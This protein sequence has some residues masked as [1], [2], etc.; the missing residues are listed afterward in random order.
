MH[1]HT[2][3]N[4]HQDTEDNYDNNSWFND[5]MMIASTVFRDDWHHAS[6]KSTKRYLMNVQ[7]ELVRSQHLCELLLSSLSKPSTTQISKC[8]NI[9]LELTERQH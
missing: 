1:T 3:R 4:T 6:A 8:T 9:Q 2:K 7:W 5:D